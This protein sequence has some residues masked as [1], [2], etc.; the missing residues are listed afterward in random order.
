[1]FF[2][3]STPYCPLGQPM[4]EGTFGYMVELLLKS[5]LKLQLDADRLYDE[6]VNAYLAGLLV[7]YIDPAYLHWIRR[8]LAPCDVD[9]HEAVLGC[10]ED[11]VQAYWI[12]K[13]N[14]DDLLMAR[15]LFHGPPA[16]EEE[17]KQGEV[18]RLKRYYGAASQ[19]QRRIYGR[20]TAV[21]E[22]HS[23]LSGE[24]ERYLTI[25]STTRRD[26]LQFVQQLSEEEMNQ[27]QRKK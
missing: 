24:A 15:G 27:L 6:D 21:G 2:P 13:V 1:M 4:P 23:K 3:L 14:A 9:L 11:R 12:Y 18:V 7:S 22:V 16:P 25:L 5:R 20:P 26:Y 19:F 17:E 10:R 8:I